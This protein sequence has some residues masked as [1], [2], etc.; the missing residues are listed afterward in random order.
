MLMRDYAWSRIL[1][2]ACARNSDVYIHGSIREYWMC[3]TYTV[4]VV[5]GV[6]GKVGKYLIHHAHT[7]S[8][9]MQ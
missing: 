9:D 5:G 6:G 4:C 2:K 8:N 7:V 1:V 3:Y